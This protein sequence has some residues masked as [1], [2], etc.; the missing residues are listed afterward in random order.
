MRD[1]FGNKGSFQNCFWNLSSAS[2]LSQVWKIRNTWKLPKACLKDNSDPLLLKALKKFKYNILDAK[3]FA[4]Q[5]FLEFEQNHKFQ[6]F[7]GEP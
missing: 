3:I 2:G 1:F 5:T 4:H 6:R 7:A